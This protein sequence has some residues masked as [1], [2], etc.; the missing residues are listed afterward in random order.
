MPTCHP[1]VPSRDSGSHICSAQPTV[2]PAPTC[3][4]CSC[5]PASGL[6]HLTSPN[7]CPPEPGQV[8]TTNLVK[9]F[10]HMPGILGYGS[11]SHA[12][13]SAPGSRLWLSLQLLCLGSGSQTKAP[14]TLGPLSQILT[15]LGAGS[16]SKK[17][18]T[19]GQTTERPSPHLTRSD[20]QLI[21]NETKHS[22]ASLFTLC[23]WHQRRGGPFTSFF[24]QAHLPHPQ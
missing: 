17:R 6:G 3:W 18:R 4:P 2:S 11:P 9:F 5:T 1:C 19:K 14:L 23:V 20:S 12:V 10:L 24:S 15:T 13:S 8:W 7:L 21:L 16:L 22:A